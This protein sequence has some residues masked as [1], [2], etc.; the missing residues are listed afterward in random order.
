M[1]SNT[2]FIENTL[3]QLKM[4]KNNIKEIKGEYINL[5][6]QM[7]KYFK[8][9]FET[10]FD[11]IIN[12]IDDYIKW[13]N[14]LNQLN[15]D[16]TIQQNVTY[17]NNI[18]SRYNKLDINLSFLLKPLQNINKFNDDSN[19]ILKDIH[20]L[21]LQSTKNNSGNFDNINNKTGIEFE[22]SLDSKYYSFY[23][24]QADINLSIINNNNIINASKC[25]FCKKIATYRCTCPCK[26][27]CCES[28]SAFI[29]DEPHKLV[30]IDENLNEIEKENE[31]QNENEKNK[32]LTSFI[33]IIKDY[34]KKCDYI[35]KKGNINIKDK[36]SYLKFQFPS[37]KDLKNITSQTISI[38]LEQ[39]N[40]SYEQI[41]KEY[42]DNIINNEVV[43]FKL[44]KSF[45]QSIYP[46]LRIDEKEF[47]DFDYDFITDEKYTL[48][49]GNQGNEEKEN[50]K[51]TIIK[52][53]I[54]DMIYYIIY[55][56]NK[57]NDN[58]NEGNINGDILNKISQA[59][60]VEKGTISIVNNNKRIFIDNFIKSDIFSKLPP[61]QI[62]I[63]YPDLP[64]LYEIKLLIDGLIRFQSNIPIEKINNK[65][66]FIIP[67]SSLSEKRG[68][69]IYHPPYGWI[70]IGL[71]ISII[72]GNEDWIKLNDE[73]SEW[74]IA[75][76][77]FGKKL[78][79]DKIMQKLYDIIINNNLDKNDNI[80]S[81]CHCK[82]RR[83]STKVGTGIYMSNYIDIAEQFSGII[84]FNKKKYKIA[85]MARV[86]EKKIKEPEDKSYWILNNKD[87]RFYRIL[88]KEIN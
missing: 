78:T 83:H 33:E 44:K 38:F 77:G 8:D 55:I 48:D 11:D 66:N 24:S 86:L 31:N 51:E 9:T 75:Y 19:K 6:T 65:Y 72:Y 20:E 84:Y 34:I 41:K 35:L 62:R 12:N 37:I 25:E 64:K 45:I 52:K 81:K 18:N 56:Y 40:E 47:N 22:K 82:D 46:I 69:E 79:S 49:Q 63:N 27:K 3:R 68:N 50:N 23:G 85:L 43:S 67:N 73:K 57:D 13:L 60:S 71:N 28:C 54:Y 26:I 42:N 17:Y 53:K 39:F 61:S 88:L 16:Q 74:V 14:N 36:K 76:Y 21:N 32:F 4:V 80:Q 7:K 58:N 1:D 30:K 70:G 5:I 15:N 2:S 59:L 87:I 29:I 10:E